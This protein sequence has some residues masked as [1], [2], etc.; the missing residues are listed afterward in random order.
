[1]NTVEVEGLHFFYYLTWQSHND[2]SSISFI[3]RDESLQLILDEKLAAD[4][5]LYDLFSFMD[6]Y[7]YELRDRFDFIPLFQQSVELFEIKII[8]KDISS[9][10]LSGVIHE[11]L[12]AA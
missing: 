4:K 12:K 3:P 11:Y 9:K 7:F 1:M 8:K 5:V 10:E 2:A 6:E